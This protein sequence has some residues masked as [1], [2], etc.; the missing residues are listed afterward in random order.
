MKVLTPFVYC[1]FRGQGEDVSCQRFSS[2]RVEGMAFCD[3]HVE[4]VSKLLGDSGVD[5]VKDE[6][7]VLGRK[8]RGG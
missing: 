4:L 5:L 8:A 7:V 6:I 2:G 3:G 1:E